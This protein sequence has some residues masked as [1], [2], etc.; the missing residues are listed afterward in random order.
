L[1]KISDRSQSIR[2]EAFQLAD[3]PEIAFIVRFF[4][5]RQSGVLACLEQRGI[6]T[7]DPPSHPQIAV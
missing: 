5:M 1:K 6:L 7:A 3:W 2:T 4:S